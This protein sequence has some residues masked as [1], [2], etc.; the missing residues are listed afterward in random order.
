MSEDN[1]LNEIEEILGVKVRHQNGKLLRKV[2]I[3]KYKRFFII[4]FHKKLGF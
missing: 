1:I 2:G 4:I 3:K